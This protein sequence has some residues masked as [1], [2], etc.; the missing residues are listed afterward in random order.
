MKFSPLAVAATAFVCGPSLTANA[1][2]PVHNFVASPLNVQGGAPF[3]VPSSSTQLGVFGI[4]GRS[5]TKAAAAPSKTSKTDAVALPT[6]EKEAVQDLFY[7][8]NDALKTLEPEIVAKRYT[9]NPI[10]LPTVSDTPRTDYDGI[11]DYFTSFLKVKITRSFC[12]VL[13][14]RRHSPYLSLMLH[15]FLQLKPQGEIVMSQVHSGPGWAKDSGLYEFTMGATGQRVKARYSFVYIYENGQWKIL[16]HHS[17]QMPEEITPNNAPK[18]NEEQVRNLFYLWNDAL[19]TLDADAVA[20]R[21]SKNAVLLPTVSDDARTDNES[22]KEYFVQF[23]KLKPQ[24]KILESYVECGPNW[25]KDVGVYE[26]TLR[27]DGN[28]KVKARYTFLYTYEDGQWKISHQHSSMM[29]ED[30]IKASKAANAEKNIPTES[31][32]RALFTKW[33]DALDTLDSKKVADC[34]TKNAVLLPT[35]S[36]KARTN[37]KDIQ[38]YFDAFLLR[39]PQGVILESYVVVGDGWAKDCGVYEFTLRNNGEKVMARYT[40]TYTLEDGEWKISHQ[41]SSAMPEGLMAKA[42][43]VDAMEAET[44]KGKGLLKSLLG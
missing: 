31:E 26:F 10:L 21:F 6:L 17:S 28:R 37:L 41:H 2:V 3:A 33:N 16:H 40:F 24:G 12:V 34:Y 22:I 27:G 42:A 8:W 35:V 13:N 32:V 18:L 43:K 20:S 29:P 36:D 44:A 30:L 39:K 19:D 7:L 15:Q 14:Q 5:A 25:A 1:F 38:S 9:E 4:F 11:I 23:L